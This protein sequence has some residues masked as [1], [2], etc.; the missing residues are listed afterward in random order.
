M[1][2]KNEFND[3][4]LTVLKKSFDRVEVDL[5]KSKLEAN[6]IKVLLKS[7]TIGGAYSIS[8][9][10]GE[11]MI[12]VKTEDLERAREVLNDEENRK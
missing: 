10:H 2:D 12:L 4:G 8:I 6:E 1:K 11:I 7:D 5:V 3:L 9:G